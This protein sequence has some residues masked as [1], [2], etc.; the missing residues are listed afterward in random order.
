M[1]ADILELDYRGL[2]VAKINGKAWFVENALPL[3]RVQIR[4]LE[5]KRQYGRAVVQKILQPSPT[6][7][8]PKCQY[9][10]ICGGCRG[11]H[12]SIESQR[13]AKQNA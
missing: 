12:I 10:G 11:Q 4:V 1:I 9:Y 8:I 13:D 5:E 7:Q 3:E 2:G 6:R